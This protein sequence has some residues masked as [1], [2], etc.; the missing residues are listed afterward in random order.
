MKN[1]ENPSLCL[2]GRALTATVIFLIGIL[3]IIASGG[4]GGGDTPPPADT[5]PPTTAAAPAGGAYASVQQITLTCSDGGGSGC[6]DTYYTSDGSDPTTSSTLYT[7]PIDVTAN[8]T[9]RF[10]SV[11]NSG[12]SEVVRVE[13]YIIDLSAPTT[14]ASPAGGSYAAAQTVTLSCDD[15]SGG[16]G[17]SATH[18]TLDGS[19]PT[20]DSSIYSSPIT[21]DAT[22]TLRFFSVD[23]V[24]N[25]EAPVTEVYT[26]A[27]PSTPVAPLYPTNGANWNDYVAVDGTNRFAATDVSCDRLFDDHYAVCIHAGEF[28]MMDVPGAASCAGLEA[29][30]TLGAFNWTCHDDGGS[31]RVISSGLKDDADLSDLID[32]TSSPPEWKSNSVSVTDG[33]AM[34]ASSTDSVWWTNPITVDNDGGSLGSAGTIYA[35]TANP[36]ARYTID[37]E[38]IGLVI[39]PGVTITAPA[40]TVAIGMIVAAGLDIRYLW[41]EGT[42][43]ASGSWAGIQWTAVNSS[44]LRN[45]KIANADT[46]GVTLEGGASGNYLNKL[47]LTNNTFGQFLGGWSNLVRNLTST[48]NIFGSGID[49]GV[50]DHTLFGITASNNARG[51]SYPINSESTVL[52]NL[53]AANNLDGIT[54]RLAS[55]NTLH[56]VAAVNNGDGVY[57][58][59]GSEGNL[60]TNLAASN[61]TTGI[62]IDTSNFNVFS[63]VLK[64]GSNT[65]ADCRVFGSPA[66]TDPG[67]Q[68]STCAN[69]G[70]SDAAL[71]TGISAAAA[72]LDKVVADDSAN[73]SDTNGTASFDAITDWTSFDSLYRGWGK[74]GNSFADLTNRDACISG[75]TC[76][77][78]DWR[79][80]NGDTGDAGSPSIK[81]VNPLPNADDTITHSWSALSEAVCNRMP[82][83]SWD[84]GAARCTSTFLRHSIEIL[85][86]G[87][88]NENGLCESNETCLFTPNFGSYQGHGDLISVGT[89]DGGAISNVTLVRYEVNGN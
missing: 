33:V 84:A 46:H 13:D 34:V 52:I 5:T 67:L 68:D 24:A 76:R 27:P 56:N 36:N 12:N 19:D 16:S 23:A 2:A 73:A 58:S 51:V 39:Q 48:N 9:I 15:G 45:I 87:L 11:D 75:E 42:I 72:F 7:V 82:G 65:T 54:A 43:D 20:T 44:V 8:T 21:V 80:A 63:G 62:T 59:F 79:L 74:D 29:T 6:A 50:G 78:W 18:Y 25:A 61:N 53:S 47:L 28:R 35:I 70:A 60:F 89:V 14:N 88:G 37:A 3:T 26:I 77:I 49:V 71:T 57:L 1:Q 41:I 69:Q 17:C 86:D 66:P 38:K 31:V 83:A 4:G 40:S 81:D 85:G 10:F 64:V 55:N 30:D 22:T 32:W